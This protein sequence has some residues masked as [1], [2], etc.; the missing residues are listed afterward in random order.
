MKKIVPFNNILNFSTDIC[1][2]TAISLEHDITSS[3]DL[4]TGSFY[5]SG[6]YKITDGDIKRENF[7]FELPFD[8]ALGSNYDRETL[9]VDIDDFRYEVIERNKLKV[10]IDLY[11]DGEIIEEES[12]EVI[13]KEK[14]YVTED[15]TELITEND[16]ANE[17]STEGTEELYE[18][19]PLLEE[20]LNS[21]P[22][23]TEVEIQ[24]RLELF[25]EMLENNKEEIMKEQTII[26]NNINNNDNTEKNK[27]IF[28]GFDELENYVTYRVYRVLENDTLDK[29]LEKYQI[30]KE[31][32]SKYN[33]IEDI[34]TGDKLI[35]P[36]NDK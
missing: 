25:D 16:I 8:I 11:I 17:D 7:D 2:I 33:N 5:I 9:I 32:L 34:K 19:L 12:R 24:K 27:E 28:N 31:E 4:I 1:E 15:R 6:E 30:T 3:E 10:N 26:N 18:G 23:P 20:P 14:E 29:I 36:A 21:Y 22:E 13:D 35:I